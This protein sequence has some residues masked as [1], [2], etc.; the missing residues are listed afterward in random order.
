MAAGLNGKARAVSVVGD[1]P[2]AGEFTG[3]IS[4]EAPQSRVAEDGKTVI[5]GTR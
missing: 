2:V 3:T 1:N 5:E 4:D